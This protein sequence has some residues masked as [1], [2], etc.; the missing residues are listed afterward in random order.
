MR[1]VPQAKMCRREAVE[2]IAEFMI[3]QTQMTQ[4]P[5]S[6]F[7]AVQ[8]V[9]PTNCIM[10]ELDAAA[11]ACRKEPASSLSFRLALFLGSTN[12][13]S[14]WVTCVFVMPLASPKGAG[15]R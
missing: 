7:I 9:Y 15:V 13:S 8:G 5:D 4:S 3:L 11:S 2:E 10:G 12:G 14:V 6:I 1:V